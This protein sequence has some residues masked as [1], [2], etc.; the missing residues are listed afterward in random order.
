VKFK[1]QGFRMQQIDRFFYAIGKKIVSYQ[2]FVL[3]L[4]LM[5]AIGF[6]SNLPKTTID[7][8]TEGFLHKDDPMILDYNAFRDQF[9]RDERIALAIKTNDI[10][11]FKHLEKLRD[12]HNE[13]KEN[14]PY[15]YDITSLINARNTIGSENSLLV[16][17][18][19]EHWPKNQ[20]ELD[21]IK[22]IALK[23]PIYK[24]LLL[25]EDASFTMI[26]LESNTYSALNVKDSEEFE[27]FEEVDTQTPRAFITDKEN[28]DMVKA[29][30]KIIQKYKSDD[31]KIYLAGSPSVTQYLK[32]AMQKDMAKFNGLIILTIIIFLSLIF[33]RVSGVLLP[34]LTVVLAVLSTMGIMAY[35]GTPIKIPTQIIPSFLLAVGVGT[36]VH[37]LAI[38]Y[39]HFDK[40]GDKAEAIAY[41]LQHSGFAILMTS[42]TTAAGVSSF[43]ISSVAPVSDLG[44]FA[45]IGVLI[46]LLY[47]M[48]LLPTLL[49]IL[50][51]KQK[52]LISKDHKDNL[53]KILSYLA[54]FSQVHALK[55][56][57]VSLV[58]MV[59]SVFI[60]SHLTYSHNPL[61]WFD[62]KSDIRVATQIIDKELKGSINLEIVIDTHKE[63]GLYNYEL[64][65]KLEKISKDSALIKT[66]SYFVGKV[67]S[68]VDVIKE[69]H[70][71][72]NENQ[73]N[74]Y[75]I[76]KDKQL[77]AQEILLFEN[78]GS[79]DLEDFVD[80]KLS[81]ARIT[82][83]MPWVDSVEYYQM[84]K[85]LQVYLKEELGDSASVTVTGMIPLLAEVITSAIYSS[86]QSYLIAFVLIT[87]MM[88]GLLS[89]V[90]LGL[91]S[92]I[93]NLFPIFFLLATMVIFSLPFDLFTM[94]V[95]SIVLGLAVDDNVH[96]MHNFR[97]YHSRENQSV[98]E[99]VRSTLL[100]SG[101]AMLITTIVLSIGFYVY[102]FASMSNLFNFGLLAGSS[103]IVA[104]LSDLILAPALMA[105]LYKKEK[106]NV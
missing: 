58:F 18:L 94:L 1:K 48:I 50:P 25:N 72:L 99:A 102:L 44:V 103:L 37:I 93:P 14:T 10:F 55:I 76:P 27:E 100:E 42:L 23:N 15:L 68:I 80:S 105:L 75:V 56:V 104:L 74:Y 32:S 30:D 84:I 70:K 28:S 98:E 66:D 29:V 53:D 91:I 86:G 45:S 6:I 97:R 31:F 39:K 79:D 101:R 24:N 7:T 59:G 64:L 26:I 16:E 71:A 8:S 73:D 54:H 35:T 69:I 22:K 67:I 49:S 47:S 88:M 78:S 20:E 11:N 46:A 63:N 36:S 81:K 40:H 77:I 95:G 85:E 106:K 9:G 87:V 51:V 82:Y 61:K 38:F 52:K 4:M 13:L 41:T 60:A 43:M 21:K 34:L 89:S 92:M 33:K 3:A 12:L 57:I 62:E 96:F 2:Y 90:K 5:L 17:D 83:K 65:K 19:F